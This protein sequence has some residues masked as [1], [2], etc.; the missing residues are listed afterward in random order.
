MSSESVGWAVSAGEKA[1]RD[2]V[3]AQKEDSHLTAFMGTANQNEE[4]LHPRRF[5][6]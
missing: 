1:T 5:V 3:I 6:Q 2:K 4:L